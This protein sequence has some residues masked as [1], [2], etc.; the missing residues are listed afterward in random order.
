VVVHAGGQ[1]LEE[2]TLAGEVEKT[3]KLLV[4]S[5]P[6][7]IRSEVHDRL[8]VAFGI[9]KLSDYPDLQRRFVQTLPNGQRKGARWNKITS[10]YSQFTP[11]QQANQ[12][13]ANPPQQE[14]GSGRKPHAP[15]Q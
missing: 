4:D 14:P 13:A 11:N 5:I 3:M 8:M 6:E 12:G 15:K 2:I 7:K 9:R 1:K 10:W